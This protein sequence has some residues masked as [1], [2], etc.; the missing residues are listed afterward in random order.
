MNRL[1]AISRLSFLLLIAVIFKRFESIIKIIKSSNVNL[2]CRHLKLFKKNSWHVFMWP[3]G[4]A[5][6]FA[7]YVSS[8]KED[9]K[10][11]FTNALRSKRHSVGVTRINL[12]RDQN[13]LFHVVA[14]SFNAVIFPKHFHSYYLLQYVPSFRELYIADRTPSGLLGP[15]VHSSTLW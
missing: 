9:E 10:K 5:Y 15:S 2:V 12:W 3:L 14:H 11:H 6:V 1:R 7:L 4:Y 13:V 8:G